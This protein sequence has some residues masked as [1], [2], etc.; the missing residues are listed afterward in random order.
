MVSGKSY[1]ATAYNVDF[2]SGYFMELYDDME[3]SIGH[4]EIYESVGINKT[5]FR[6]HKYFTIL[7]QI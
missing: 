1:P 7:G 6:T 3:R 5:Y 2:E 4:S